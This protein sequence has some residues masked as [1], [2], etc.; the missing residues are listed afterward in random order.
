M[1]CDEPTG[2]LD[3]RTGVEIMDLF[4]ELNDQKE[5]TL[6]MVTHEEHIAKMA[7]RVIRMEDG[8]IVS[9]EPNEPE[10]PEL[11]LM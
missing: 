9:D 6:V 8:K 5:I 3:R 4:S 2:S 1:L 10:R 11:E 7:R